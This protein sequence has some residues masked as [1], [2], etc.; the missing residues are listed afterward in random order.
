VPVEE[1]IIVPAEKKPEEKKVI[2]PAAVEKPKAEAP[3]K[4]VV[5]VEEK[6]IVPAEKKPEEKKVIAPAAVEKPKVVAPAKA[7][8]P[9][10]EKI[11]VPAEKKPEKKPEEKPEE[12]KVI[13]P[14]AV[15]KPKAE[16]SAKTGDLSDSNME[17][18]WVD[19]PITEAR[20][21][22]GA[23]NNTLFRLFIWRDIIVEFSRHWP[24]LGFSFGKPFRSE[25]L[26]ILGWGA[27]EWGRDGW[28]DPHNSYLDMLYRMGILGVALIGFLIWQFFHMIKGFIIFR[29]LPGLLLC[30]ILINWSVAAN[31]LPILELPHSSI[32]FWALWGVALG[33]LKEL[34]NKR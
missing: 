2:A 6:I 32:P 11:T 3:A 22:G 33:Y 12:K 14:A 34:K 8:A 29:S 4:T 5:P 27:G 30:S 26:E 28:I 20:E 23:T 9:I 10:E 21:E 13:A 31:F 16:A 15:E 18:V 7:V 17:Y 25:S 1:K 19:E 24:I